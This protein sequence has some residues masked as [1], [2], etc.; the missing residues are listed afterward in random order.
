MSDQLTD[1]LVKDVAKRTARVVFEKR[2]N[3][4]EAHIGEDEL[5]IIVEAA[6]RW[7]EDRKENGPS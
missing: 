7:Y 5:R 6:I 1:R 3:H 2:G 4:A